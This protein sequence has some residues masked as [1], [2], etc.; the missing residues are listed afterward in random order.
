M[1]RHPLAGALLAAPNPAVLAPAGAP[2]L[3]AP[4]R[5]AVRA[6]PDPGSVAGV[7][8]A[9]QTQ[10]DHAYP[11]RLHAAL[12]RLGAGTRTDL[13]A[14]L[15]QWLVERYVDA[16]PCEHPP[17]PAPTLHVQV[18]GQFRLT[19]DDAPLEFGV[20]PATRALDILRI[21]AI[22]ADHTCS[23]EHLYDWLW[24]DADGDNAKAAC[25]QALHRLRKLLGDPELVIQREGKLQLARERVRVDLDAWE[26]RLKQALHVDRPQPAGDAEL[27]R[28]FFDFS[29]PLLQ[30]ERANA[31]SLPA[32]ERVR[33]KL[34]DLAIR[35]GQ[36]HEARGGFARAQTAYL[37][38]LDFYPASARLYEALIRARL[39]QGDRAGALEDYG[40]FERIRQTAFNTPASSAIR[41]LIEPLL[42][43]DA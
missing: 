19:R 29:G 39:A 12:S 5:R 11:Q 32:A 15:S 28:V 35:L 34:L 24:P 25:D 37:H 22:A 16:A 10:W 1:S 31:W 40:R 42:Y 18:L 13:L 6:V 30:H 4:R 9:L 14:K 26:L 27:E 33:S 21:L 36:R 41:R 3:P 7:V 43:P 38:A 17:G 23:L 2:A 20:K 8:H